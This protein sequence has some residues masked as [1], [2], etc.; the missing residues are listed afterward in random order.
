ML[1]KIHAMALC[2]LLGSTN[3]LA[4][5][6]VAGMNLSP[7]SYGSIPKK[8]QT[9]PTKDAKRIEF[10]ASLKQWFPP[11]RNQEKTHTCLAH[12]V[13]SA[14]TAQEARS[15]GRTTPED[16]Q[17][18]LYSA[19]Y[20][21][22]AATSS[23]ACDAGLGLDEF[24]KGLQESGILR[25]HL[26]PDICI[27]KIDSKLLEKANKNILEA[28]H[29]LFECKNN[30]NAVLMIKEAIT[31][32]NPVVIGLSGLDADASFR[33]LKSKSGEDCLWKPSVAQ[34]CK[35]AN[36]YEGHAVCIVGYDDYK[37]GENEG[38]F[39]ILN[40]DGDEWGNKG[41]AWI[42]YRDLVKFT[43][44]AIEILPFCV[45]DIAT[46]PQPSKSAPTQP[47]KEKFNSNIRLKKPG[48]GTILE[49]DQTNVSTLGSL[50]IGSSPSGKSG[51]QNTQIL[52]E[53]HRVTKP[54]KTGD[55]YQIDLE[56]HENAY[57]YVFNVDMQNNFDILFPH[58]EAHESAFIQEQQKVTLPSKSTAIQ[59]GE[60]TGKDYL[61]IFLSNTALN[62]DLVKQTILAKQGDFYDRLVS[63]V[64]VVTTPQM[65]KIPEKPKPTKQKH[66]I[67]KLGNPKQYIETKLE[68]NGGKKALVPIVIEFDHQ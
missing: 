27:P 46:V 68:L 13:T 15:T 65:G 56:N 21:Y 58:K 45:S 28:F 29:I 53:S 7:S 22:R 10:V 23:P 2:A 66:S 64:E 17:K 12:A 50:K 60:V 59:L 41:Y 30:S 37:F 43:S 20:S 32:Q 31:C 26:S 33:N 67:T 11:V 52:Y 24:A 19:G 38:G 49:T 55:R 14:F 51:N 40:S 47:E 25:N 61:C 18:L 1:K 4:Q 39:E 34:P 36:C 54:M 3:L 42:S 62:I 57:V 44:V 48:S 9:D 35:C 8:P 5:K 63:A 6:R 16:K